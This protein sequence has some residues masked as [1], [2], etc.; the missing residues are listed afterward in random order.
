MRMK[1]ELHS[2][3]HAPMVA[4]RGELHFNERLILVFTPV[5]KID[6]MNI[7]APCLKSGDVVESGE[8]SRKNKNTVLQGNGVCGSLTNPPFSP[9]PPPSITD[10]T[11][12]KSNTHDAHSP[13]LIPLIP[14]TASHFKE[15]KAIFL[16]RETHHETCYLC[17]YVGRM[18]RMCFLVCMSVRT[19]YA[20]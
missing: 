5:M 17:V 14:H 13:T 6:L 15:I 11:V 4:A 8:Y 19:P 1:V 9:L 12:F 16:W 2:H 20:R 18:R 3:S 10:I 7:Y